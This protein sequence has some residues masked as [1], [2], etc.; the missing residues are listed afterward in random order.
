M[1]HE[2]ALGQ[3]HAT[4]RPTTGRA[5][6][7]RLH[8]KSLHRNRSHTML[9]SLATLLITALV[10]VVAPGQTP[11][12]AGP[13][14]TAAYVSV[15][16]C[17]LAD[18]R[19]GTGFS[20]I[21]AST[22]Q[23]SARKVC[24]VPANATSL[25]LT[26]TVVNSQ[27][28]GFLT[29][30]PANQPRP[31]VSNINFGGGQI[32][33]NGSI[34]RLDSNGEFRVFTN[35]AADVVVDVVGA[36]VP[37]GAVAA[38][39]FVSRPPTRLLD[40]RSGARIAP[41]SKVTIGVPSGVPS[42]ARALALNITV[43]ESSGPGFVT[44]FP[45]GQAMPTSSVLNVD[46]ANQTRA[47]SGI[48]PVS[49]AGASL[50][51]SGG[52]HL[53]VDMVGYF[54]GPSAGAS[55]D[56]LFTAHDP[57]RLLDTRSTSPLGNGVP[58]YPAGALELVTGRGGS[59]AYN[60]TSVDGGTGFV[61]AY[62]AGT[63]RPATSSVNSVGAGDVVANFAIT[64]MSDRGLGIFSQ[65]QTHVLVDLQG[66]FSGPSAT[67]TIG[68]PANPLPPPPPPPSAPPS[69]V[70]YSACINDGLSIINS[71]RSSSAP[72]V[73]NPAAQAWA[74]AWALQMAMTGG[75]SHSNDA[76]R[77][78]AIGCGTGE[79]VGF[80]SNTSISNMFSMWFASPAHDANIRSTSYRSVGI[81]FVIRTEVNG[82]QRIFG[83]TDFA[84]C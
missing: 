5:N 84:A 56:G 71:R 53:V 50:Y 75:M 6:C 1:R 51:L 44:Q 80:S 46:Q 23:I 13:S 26:L 48:F 47:A 8:R 79:N 77:S 81:G 3:A 9:A 34:T 58:L 7:G 21:D 32:R 31:N 61:T 45:A 78:V 59:M 41:T 66:W 74:C 73:V 67:A 70:T 24:G 2:K 36:F 14:S 52:G 12:S 30:W 25:A 18:T 72:L 20:R 33:A 27:A 11:A 49:S 64:Q 38:G 22:L 15:Q 65:S 19:E 37:S 63:A 60:I 54:T 62:P 28:T 69:A 43:T 17:R 35:V 16:P 82:S 83:V 76:A 39:R 57:T 29:A 40:T 68:P 55:T 4:N 42:D 10:V